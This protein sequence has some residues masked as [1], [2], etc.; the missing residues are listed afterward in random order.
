MSEWQPI[1]TAPKDGTWIVVCTP[2]RS[3][4]PHET[5]Y[6]IPPTTV[7]WIDVTLSIRDHYF[8][9][10][11]GV[12]FWE[13]FIPPTGCHFMNRRRNKTMELRK[14]QAPEYYHP[15][16]AVSVCETNN[17]STYFAIGY[18]GIDRIEWNMRE[19]DYSYA[20]SIVVFKNGK[21]HSEHFMS[22]VLGVYYSDE[23]SGQS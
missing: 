19:G 15:I 3:S 10:T 9:W 22:Q 11:T 17:G 14:P 12:E 5:G 13:D 16:K 6:G 7:K 20:P 4:P 23:T 1:E 8:G 18:D 21:L 2:S